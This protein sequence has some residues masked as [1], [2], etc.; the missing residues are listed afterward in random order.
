[1]RPVKMSSG[2]SVLGITDFK[3]PCGEVDMSSRTV[4]FYFKWY[5]DLNKEF[6]S[7]DIRTQ[8]AKLFQEIFILNG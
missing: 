1:M 2:T 3:F 5:E 8:F 7:K 6:F 4:S